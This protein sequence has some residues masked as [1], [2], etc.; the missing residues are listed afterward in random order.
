MDRLYRTALRETLPRHLGRAFGEIDRRF[1]AFCDC[2]DSVKSLE[3][4]VARRPRRTRQI[5]LARR[6]DELFCAEIAV[7]TGLPIR[8]VERHLARAIYRLSKEL[9]RE[10]LRWWERLLGW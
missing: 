5:F 9:D 4:A 3:D 8:R 10:P 2:V 1:L 6:V 7:R